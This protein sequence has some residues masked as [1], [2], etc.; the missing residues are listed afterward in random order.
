[1]AATSLDPSAGMM[2]AGRD[3]TLP[4]ATSRDA[5]FAALRPTVGRRGTIN[6]REHLRKGRSIMG[7]A[8]DERRR[9]VRGAHAVRTGS[10]ATTRHPPAPPGDPMPSIPLRKEPKW[11]GNVDLGAVKAQFRRESS[12][13]IPLAPMRYLTGGGSRVRKKLLVGKRLEQVA[14]ANMKYHEDQMAARNLEAMWAGRD[15]DDDYERPTP[16]A[17]P[18]PD[19]D[20]IDRE[21]SSSSSDPSVPLQIGLTLGIAAAAFALGIAMR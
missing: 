8:D 10:K 15:E 9:T 19:L 5:K 18:L 14:E 13:A 16:P 3:V 17:P 4:H 7:S 21:A 6:I 1:M 2:L 11:V 12:D 20:E